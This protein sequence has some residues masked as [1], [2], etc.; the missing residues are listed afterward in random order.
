[1]EI[2][3]WNLLAIPVKGFPASMPFDKIKDNEA[4]E[5]HSLYWVIRETA[6]TTVVSSAE[7]ELSVQPQTLIASADDSLLSA[8]PQALIFSSANDSL[9]NFCPDVID[10]KGNI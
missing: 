8:Q 10:Q 4:T 5:E 1:M 9:L 7:P 3:D 6:A 2:C